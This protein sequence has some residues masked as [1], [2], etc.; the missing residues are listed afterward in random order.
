VGEESQQ[1]CDVTSLPGK[2]S[3]RGLLNTQMKGGEFR[4]EASKSSQGKRQNLTG[5]VGR[6]RGSISHTGGC[7]GSEKG[8]HALPNLHLGRTTCPRKKPLFDFTRTPVDQEARG[9]DRTPMKGRVKHSLEN[10]T[11]QLLLLH[12]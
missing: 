10:E 7:S 3:R 11:S 12:Q 5:L 4:E 2:N 1:S 8:I 6:I 9:G